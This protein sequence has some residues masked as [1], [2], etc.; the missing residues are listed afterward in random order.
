MTH[1][2]K[3]KG[4]LNRII[5][6]TPSR[7]LHFCFSL[8]F[9]SFL[10]ILLMIGETREENSV[11]TNSIVVKNYGQEQMAYYASEFS[12]FYRCYEYGMT[13]RLRLIFFHTHTYQ[14]LT[15]QYL[16]I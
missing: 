4:K 6:I 8:K 15:S 1:I 14:R 13:P 16:F 7:M 3:D 11:K 10:Q 12:K 2:L 5:K 9:S